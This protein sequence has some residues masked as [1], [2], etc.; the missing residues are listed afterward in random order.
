LFHIRR[1]PLIKIEENKNMLSRAVFTGYVF[2]LIISVVASFLISISWI[3]TEVW[4]GMEFFFAI[5]LSGLVLWVVFLTLGWVREEER[6]RYIN[7]NDQEHGWGRIALAYP[8][9]IYLP[10]LIIYT[11]LII[12]SYPY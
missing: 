1:I 7:I 10:I 3:S 8:L 2:V 6:G 4:I 9:I 12:R 5:L 11:V